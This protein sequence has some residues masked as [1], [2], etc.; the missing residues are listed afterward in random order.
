MLIDVSQTKFLLHGEHNVFAL[1]KTIDDP[2][3]ETAAV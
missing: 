3:M 1:R 2:Y